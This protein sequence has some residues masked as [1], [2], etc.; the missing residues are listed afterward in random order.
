MAGDV[1]VGGILLAA[2]ILGFRY[3]YEVSQF[4]E[5]LDAIGSTTRWDEVEPAGWKVTLTRMLSFV[6]ALVG[7][8][9]FLSGLF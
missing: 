5:R 2:G 4:D 9:F 8:S 1:L 3:A 7:A 6:V